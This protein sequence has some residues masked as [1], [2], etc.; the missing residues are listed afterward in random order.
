MLPR[1]CFSG[2][3][4]KETLQNCNVNSFFLSITS[5]FEKWKA[6]VTSVVAAIYVNLQTLHAMIYRKR[7][8]MLVA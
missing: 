3:L 4:K 7:K 8:K 6:T 2:N 1:G 5:V